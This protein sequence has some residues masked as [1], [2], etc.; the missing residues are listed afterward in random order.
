MAELHVLKQHLGHLNRHK[1]ITCDRNFCSVKGL[2]SAFFVNLMPEKALSIRKTD[3]SKRLKQFWHKDIAVK[4][5]DAFESDKNFVS[6]QT[7]VQ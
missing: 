4:S 5:P 7:A 1:K 3:I 2:N 6:E